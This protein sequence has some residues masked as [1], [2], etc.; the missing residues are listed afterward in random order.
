[1]DVQWNPVKAAANY[2]KHGIRFSEAEDILADPRALTIE[3]TGV[4]GETR[5]ISMGR[6]V[7]GRVL[8][9]VY[10]YRADHVRIISAR[11]ANRRERVTY[12]KGP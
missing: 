5:F 4:T 2:R 8:V 11:R 10:T 12:E 7:A 6:D 9:V 1:M 3:D